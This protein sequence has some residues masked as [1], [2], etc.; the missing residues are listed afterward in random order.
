[1]KMT[2]LILSCAWLAIALLPLGQAV[3]FAS[4][5]RP[6]LELHCVQCHGADKQKGDLRLDTVGQA[7][8]GGDTGPALAKGDPAKSLM[9]E[10]I[11][12]DADHDDIMP[13]KGDPLKPAQIETLR[14]WIADGAAWPGGVT[15]RAKSAADL[16]R[17]KLFAAKPLKSIE[18]FP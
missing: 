18:V 10:R 3:E 5:V 2:P 9:I 12:L 14:Q 13:P 8:K 1:M 6:L 11:S 4:D 7:E 16:E 17:E 15:L